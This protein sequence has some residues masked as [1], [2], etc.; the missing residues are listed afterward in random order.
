MTFSVTRCTLISDFELR[1]VEL[2]FVETD[3]VSVFEIRLRAPAYAAKID[4]DTA[5][6]SA[7][8]ER[9]RRT[10]TARAISSGLGSPC[11]CG[12]AANPTNQPC[13]RN[14]LGGADV[15]VLPRT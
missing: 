12:P 10:T 8:C 9:S 1:V 7:P 15:P 3:V 14:P 6:A 2:L 13:A 5:A 4:R 11:G